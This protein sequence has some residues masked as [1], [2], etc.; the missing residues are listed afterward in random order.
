MID[1]SELMSDP[2][3]CENFNI[4]R[5]VGGSFGPGGYLPQVAPITLYGA[6][7]V[8]DAETIEQ[9]PEGDRRSGA[10]VFWSAS[11]MFETNSEGLSDIIVYHGT[12]WKVVKVWDRSASGFWKAIGVREGI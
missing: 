12:K 3:F 6:V 1:T 2:D 10:R 8:A 4:L 9:V 7:Q 11:Q 5:T